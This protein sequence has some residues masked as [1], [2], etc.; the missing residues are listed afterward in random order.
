MKKVLT[1]TFET[2]VVFAIM[3]YCIAASGTLMDL[4]SDMISM[5]DIEDVHVI[6]FMMGMSFTIACVLHTLAEIAADVVET[7]M[8]KAKR[9]Y[10]QI[11]KKVSKKAAAK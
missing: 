3:W 11:S 6:T 9:F 5:F 1:I 4:M 2:L 8:I 10:R 7:V